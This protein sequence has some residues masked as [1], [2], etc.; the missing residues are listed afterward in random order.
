MEET[1]LKLLFAEDTEDLNRVVKAMLEHAGYSVDAVFDGEAALEC[2]A[3]NGYDAVILDIMMPKLDG[4]SVLRRMRGQNINL[5]VL[6]LTAKAEVNDRVEGL[7][8]GADDYLPKPFAMKE[9]LARVNAMTRRR[10]RYDNKKVTFANYSLDADTLELKAENTMRLS[11][12]EFEL[13]QLLTL[14]PGKQLTTEYVLERIWA[15][16]PEADGDT[17]F[18]YVSYLRRKLSGVAAAVQIAGER[19]GWYCLEAQ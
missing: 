7:D 6:L 5:P 4:I 2:L 12:K 13:L 18:L 15:D 9:L 10:T 19:G 11:I 8:A 1:Q 14:N 3:E 16:E 17:V